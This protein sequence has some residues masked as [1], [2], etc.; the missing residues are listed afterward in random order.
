MPL[1][2]DE[3]TSKGP[4]GEATTYISRYIGGKSMVGLKL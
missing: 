2:Y 1:I 4:R 3:G